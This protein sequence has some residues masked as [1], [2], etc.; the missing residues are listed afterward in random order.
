MPAG[1]TTDSQGGS[2]VITTTGPMQK[3]LNLLQAVSDIQRWC[4]MEKDAVSEIDKNYLTIQERYDFFAV[5]IKNAFTHFFFTL[6]LTPLTVAVLHRIIHIFGDEQLSIFDQAYALLLAFSVSLGFGIFLSSLKSCYVGNIT[7]GMI[8][9][10]FGGILIGET[11]KDILLIF[12]YIFIY[13]HITPQNVISFIL[14]LHKYLGTFL[15]KLHVDYT[16]MFYWIM[17]WKDVFSVSA[18]FVVISSVLFA[19]IPFVVII[20]SSLF[21]KPSSEEL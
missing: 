16:Q 8:N 17:Q 1:K 13:Y 20:V 7:K 19:V 12:I 3:P 21:A 4:A 15:A 2:T 9:N 6:F 11:I 10:L 5:G 14:F 18:V